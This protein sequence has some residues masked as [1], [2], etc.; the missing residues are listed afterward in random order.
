M[1]TDTTDVV[2]P[3]TVRLDS[4]LRRQLEDAAKS[5][6]RPLSREIA[7]RLAESLK[8]RDGRCERP[9]RDRRKQQFPKEKGPGA[10]RGLKI[11]KDMCNEFCTRPRR[12]AQ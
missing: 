7:F 5:S 3:T 12:S 4:V 10:N 8:D 2:I 1:S 6:F 11:R 9:S